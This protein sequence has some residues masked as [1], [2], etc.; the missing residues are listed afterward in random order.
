M[1]DDSAK[2]LTSADSVALAAGRGRSDAAMRILATIDALTRQSTVP[3]AAACP[4]PAAETTTPAASGPAKVPR[5]SPNA[6]PTFAATS[7]SGVVAA[8]GRS[9]MVV[10]RTSA[11][12]AEPTPTATNTMI[13]RS[14]TVAAAMAAAATARMRPTIGRE[15]S[16]RAN[17]PVSTT[18]LTSVAGAMRN[19]GTSPA[20]TAPP[21]S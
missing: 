9:D 20:R 14:T 18:A 8:A 13:G 12:A 11:V 1:P 6:M 15:R 5:L 10:G 19:S 21:S 4:G 3:S 17:R 16:G 7:S 2:P